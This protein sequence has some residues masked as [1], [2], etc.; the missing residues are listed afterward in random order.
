MPS[1]DV[2]VLIVNW[3]SGAMTRALIANLRRQVFPGR[4]GGQGALEFIVTDNASGAGE[5]PHLAA[6]EADPG[7]TLIRSRQNGGYAV[8]MNLAA[9][10]ATGD[11]FLISNPD[12]MAFRGALAALLEHARSNTTCGMAGPKGYLDSQ[13]FFQL[14][15]VE[16][17]SMCNLLGETLARRSTAAGER[18]ARARSR[19]AVAVWTASAPTAL[20][21][22]SGYCFLMPAPLARE[23][24]PFDPAFPF[25][26][27]DADLCRRVHGRGFRTD[28]VPRARMV[29]FFNRSASQAQDAALSRYQVSRRHY[30]GK[31]YG[32]LGNLAYDLLSGLDDGHGQGHRFAEVDDLGAPPRPPDIEVP[33]EGAYLAEIAADPGF[34]FAAGRLDVNR[35]FCIPDAVWDGLAPATY[36]VRFLERRSYRILRTVCLT[37]TTP[38]VP[39]SADDAVLEPAFA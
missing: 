15:P 4:D 23:L 10:K 12:V 9:E 13:R 1:P 34:V 6:L 35:S 19:R 2:S 26:Y 32:A 7:V 14:P 25:Y 21:Q 28:F 31:R 20:S 16:L 30:F 18:H 27:E 22:L 8:G 24:G 3:K 17:P 33:A 38:P 29:H 37:K 5:E 39:I 11:W 36:F